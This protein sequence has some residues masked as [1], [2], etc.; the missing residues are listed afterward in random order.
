MRLLATVALCGTLVACAFGP[1]GQPPEL[2]SPE[3]YGVMPTPAQTVPANGE[4]QYFVD[5]TQPVTKWWKRYGSAQ[6]DALVDEALA[7]NLDLAAARHRLE[8]AREQW[9]AQAGA[10]RLPSIDIG[11][12]AARQRDLGLPI[13][14][15]PPTSLY[16][17][18]VGQAQVQYTFDL[19]GANRYKNQ[20][21][22]DRVGQQAAELQAARNAVAANVVS[23]AI[24]LAGR[25]AQ[26]G[27]LEDLIA[28]SRKDEADTLRQ[29]AL[30]AASRSSVLDARRGAA[31][32]SAQLPE[33]NARAL[34]ARHALAVLLGRSPNQAPPALKFDS[35]VLPAQLPVLV[36]SALLASRPDVQA[37]DAALKAAAADVGAATANMFPRI[38]LSASMGRGGFDWST[39]TSGA[40]AI[41][42]LASGITA[43]V[44][45]G[46]A[47]RAQRRAAAQTYEAAVAQYK[48]TVLS[49]FQEVAD[50]LASL[51]QGSLSLAQADA[52][53]DAAQEQFENTRQQ[54]SLGAL[55]PAAARAMSRQAAQ[56]QLDALRYKTL[57]MLDTAR[58]L[59][60]MGAAP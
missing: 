36:P 55:P 2:G 52:A 56:A 15:L 29:H 48:N 20:A 35:L 33:L 14:G 54:V 7:G 57:R 25:Q 27:I 38:T 45:H 17:T 5:A 37:A 13:E 19:F 18:F 39:A 58:L 12:Q 9:S 30:G 21:L 42:S 51:E 44:F 34:A 43:P 3:H 4:T 32:L 22:A 11:A 23:G 26:I 47:L 41:W 59:H 60:A 49:A 16:N 10:T 53:Q 1:G 50:S 46:G 6:L 40:G 24:S 8:A 28:L 31:A